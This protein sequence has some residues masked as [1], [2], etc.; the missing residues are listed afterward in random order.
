MLNL[1]PSALG[2]GLVHS[3]HDLSSSR[4]VTVYKVALGLQEE[5]TPVVRRR[6]TL[7]HQPVSVTILLAKARGRRLGVVVVGAV[8]LQA[9]SL[10]PREPRVLPATLG[11]RR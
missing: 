6:S 5:S 8:R 10:Q 3:T 11:R 2:S 1:Y 9:V 4:A 7:L